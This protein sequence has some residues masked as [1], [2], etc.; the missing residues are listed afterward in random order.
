MAPLPPAMMACTSRGSVPKV[1]GISADSS[2]PSRPLVPAPTKT[3]R[4]PLRERL[5]EQVGAKRDAVALALHGQQHLPVLGEHQ[6]DDARCRQLVDCE[7]GGVDR[8]GGKGLPLRTYGHLT[9]LQAEA[10]ANRDVN[11]HRR[12][13]LR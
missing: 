10:K 4:P 3:T 8:F 2:T 13:K 11:T 7:G 6:V 12:C 9:T 5:G 1:G